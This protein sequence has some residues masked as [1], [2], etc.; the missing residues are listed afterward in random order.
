MITLQQWLICVA[1]LQADDYT[2][3]HIVLIPI[4][5]LETQQHQHQHQHQQQQKPTSTRSFI[6]MNLVSTRARKYGHT[7]TLN[8]VD[9]PR[10]P[11]VV[12]LGFR[13]ILTGV[14]SKEVDERKTSTLPAGMWKGTC[15]SQRRN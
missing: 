4:E 2:N 9:R 7:I 6:F 1:G 11:A 10:A 15:L 3:S 14:L 5:R 12:S 8:G 13:N